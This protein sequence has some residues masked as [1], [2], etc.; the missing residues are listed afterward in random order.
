MGVVAGVNDSQDGHAEG[1]TSSLG[2]GRMEIGAEEVWNLSSGAD[3]GHCLPFAAWPVG[4]PVRRW[5]V[6]VR[7]GH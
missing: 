6:P 1:E 2:S 3:D 7:P 5:P 4:S